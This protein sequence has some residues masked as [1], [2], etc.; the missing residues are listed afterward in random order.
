MAA[1]APIPATAAIS[2]S[3][4]PDAASAP[5]RITATTTV[6]SAICDPTLRSIPSE[7]MTNV[8]PSAAMPMMTLWVRIVLML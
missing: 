8:I 2:G 6:A 7:T 5:F 1:Q 4:N 3:I